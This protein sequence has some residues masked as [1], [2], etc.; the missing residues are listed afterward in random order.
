MPFFRIHLRIAV[1]KPI[2][3]QQMKY[4]LLC[5][6][7]NEL[8]SYQTAILYD[9]DPVTDGHGVINSVCDI[10]KFPLPLL[11]SDLQSGREAHVHWG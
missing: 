9:G 6:L 11:L 3:D 4:L 10:K 8:G 1:L 5:R 7:L 2:A